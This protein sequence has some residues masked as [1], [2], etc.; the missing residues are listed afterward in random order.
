MTHESKRETEGEGDKSGDSLGS[1][2]RLLSGL[3][4]FSK[5]EGNICFKKLP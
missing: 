2:L 4:M 1:H 3:S 5:S